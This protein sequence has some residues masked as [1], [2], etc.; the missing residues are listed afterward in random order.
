MWHCGLPPPF[1]ST[2]YPINSSKS[3][4]SVDLSFNDH[5]VTPSLFK[6]LGKYHAN[7]AYLDLYDT[8]Y[9]DSIPDVFENMSSL[10]YLD[11]SYNQ[12]VGGIPP[13]F[14]KLCSLQNLMLSSN[15][16]NGQFSMFVQI[17]STCAQNSSSNHAKFSSLRQ[18][19]LSGNQLSGR[20]PESIGK[21][22]RWRY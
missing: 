21:C 11:M 18:L 2:F 20:V 15:K 8:Q 16:L 4:A 14:A 12:L 7:L 19:F 9:R 10:T 5:V 1:L 6:W 13:S 3:L 17:L 22:H